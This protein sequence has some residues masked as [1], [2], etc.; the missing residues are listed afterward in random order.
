MNR[1]PRLLILTSLALAGRAMGQCSQPFS[2]NLFDSFRSFGTPEVGELQNPAA[3]W[4]YRVNSTAGDMLSGCLSGPVAAWGYPPQPY[5]VPLVG[6]LCSPDGDINENPYHDRPHSM[7]AVFMHPGYNGYDSNVAFWPTAPVTLTA[8]TVDGEVVGD[9]SDGVSIRVL[10]HRH[11]TGTDTTLIPASVVPYAS[12]G[13]SSFSASAGTLPLTLNGGDEPVF[14]VINNNGAP[15]EDWFSGNITLTMTGGPVILA[16]PRSAGACQNTPTSIHVLAA[17]SGALS[18]RWQK[19]SPAGS[20]QY[21]DLSDGATAAGSTIGGA[22]T[23]T[24]TV[25]HASPSDGGRYRCR[26]TGPCA[27]VHSAAGVIAPCVSDFDCS[28]FVDTDDFTAFV[29]SFEAGTDDADVDGTGFVDTD[30]FTFFVL[31]F[32]SGC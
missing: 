7:N 6:P 1:L 9:I 8:V 32:E 14:M 23:D 26:I 27:T 31:A 22:L 20:G 19:E 21:A 29:L 30:D 2:V 17:G 28:G 18:Y 5:S 24:L 16:Q 3:P 25:I 11:A 4:Q 10:A 12:S 13:H 15:F